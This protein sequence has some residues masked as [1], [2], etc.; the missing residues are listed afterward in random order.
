MVIVIFE[1]LN[2]FKNVTDVP[3]SPVAVTS[4]LHIQTT[5]T[6]NTQQTT[7]QTVPQHVQTTPVSSVPQHVQTTPVSSVP[8]HVQTTSS[9]EKLAYNTYLTKFNI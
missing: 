8:Q 2:Y 3:M 4:P 5:P 9:E 1:S 7:Q 6:S